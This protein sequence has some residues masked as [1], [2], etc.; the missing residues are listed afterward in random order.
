MATT[1]KK[2][3]VV[4]KARPIPDAGNRPKTKIPGMKKSNTRMEPTLKD[5]QGKKLTTRKKS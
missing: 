1:K 3:T 2:V 4:P 5:K